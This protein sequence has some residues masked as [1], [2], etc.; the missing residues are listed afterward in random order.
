MMALTVEERLERIE[1]LLA[2]SMKEIF[3]V[4][5]AAAFIGVSESRLYHLTSAKEIPHY[6]KGNSTFFRKSE[7]EEWMTDNSSRVST[8]KE[9]NRKA[10]T[11]I[12]KNQQ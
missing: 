8:R 5:E 7:L 6:K 1:L 12:F 10:A 11:V 3:D 9:L 2:V 4:H